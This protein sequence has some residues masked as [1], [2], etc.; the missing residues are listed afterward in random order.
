MK[1]QSPRCKPEQID[2]CDKDKIRGETRAEN[3]ESALAHAGVEIGRKEKVER[4]Q[5]RIISA[6]RV[7]S[8]ESQTR[9]QKND[10]HNRHTAFSERGNNVGHAEAQPL[11]RRMRFFERKYNAFHG[12][13]PFFNLS[14]KAYEERP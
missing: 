8:S 10:K 6:V 11:R 9:K 2:C 12:N 1:R 14:V 4:L 7:R 5:R 3:P 13:I